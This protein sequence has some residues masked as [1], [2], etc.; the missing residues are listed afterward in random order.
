MEVAEKQEAKKQSAVLMPERFGLA[1]AKRQDFVADVPSDVTLEQVLDP[2]YW[3]HTAISM[4]PGDQIEVRWEDGS[5]I[6]LLHVVFCERNYARVE[7]IW[8]KEIK[9][10]IETPSASIKHRVDWKG[11][12][13]KWC[14]VRVSDSQ[15]ISKENSSKELAYQWM[16]NHE[17]AQGR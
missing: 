9:V 12:H 2:A 7:T 8:T 3:A 15:V 11:P 16:Q 17:R 5:R 4:T 13:L 6:A 1:E 14:V 10:N